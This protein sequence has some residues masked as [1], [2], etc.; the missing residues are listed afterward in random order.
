LSSKDLHVRVEFQM[1]TGDDKNWTKIGQVFG[2]KNYQTLTIQN[3]L[4]LGRGDEIRLMLQDGVLHSD[5]P[6]GPITSFSGWLMEE[7]IF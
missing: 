1:K 6:F 4:Q 7:D 2:G 5:T 3:I